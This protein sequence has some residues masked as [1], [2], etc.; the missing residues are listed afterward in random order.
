MDVNRCRLAIRQRFLAPIFRLSGCLLLSLASLYL[1]AVNFP[2]D[3]TLAHHISA[4]IMSAS[5]KILVYGGRGSLGSVIV[6][7]LKSK[8]IV[9]MHIE[10]RIITN[11]FHPTE[12]GTYVL[13]ELYDLGHIFFCWCGLIIRMECFSKLFLR[14]C[15]RCLRFSG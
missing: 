5:S 9:R 6:R 12:I 1:L 3:N 11:K 14:I 13:K 7:H 15:K 10:Y 8:N 2:S 4:K